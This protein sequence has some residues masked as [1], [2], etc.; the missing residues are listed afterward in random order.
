VF[1]Y[2]VFNVLKGVNDV[3]QVDME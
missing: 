3:N 1:W 2:E